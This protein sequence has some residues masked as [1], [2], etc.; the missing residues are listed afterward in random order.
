MKPS[1]SVASVSRAEPGLQSC[2]LAAADLGWHV[3]PCAPGS[4]R[5]ALKDNWQDLATT[6]PDRIRCWWGRQPY[7]IGIACRPSGLVVIDLD[8]EGPSGDGPS[9]DGTASLESLCHARSEERRVGKECR[10]RGPP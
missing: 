1:V 9:R 4:K 8:A 2:A 7:N 10:S 3:F 5:P 6:D